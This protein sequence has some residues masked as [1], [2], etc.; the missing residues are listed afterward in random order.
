MFR[1]Y[2]FVFIKGHYTFADMYF[3]NLN[4]VMFG[5]IASANSKQVLNM[6]FLL[7]L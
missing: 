2:Q 4:G 7:N 5:S 3:I 6:Q 1:K